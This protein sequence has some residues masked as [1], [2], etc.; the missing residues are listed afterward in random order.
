[1]FLWKFLIYFHLIYN[2]SAFGCGFKKF[3]SCLFTVFI[4]LADIFD[5]MFDLIINNIIREPI[6]D[7]ML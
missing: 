2:C 3:D 6:I 4:L 5:Y 7:K 1:M